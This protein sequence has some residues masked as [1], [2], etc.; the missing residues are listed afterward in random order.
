MSRDLTI[1]MMAAID[2]HTLRAI[3][4]LK[5]EINEWQGTKSSGSKRVTV[6]DERDGEDVKR[7]KSQARRE[8]FKLLDERSLGKSGWVLAKLPS[9]NFQNSKPFSL[10][11]RRSSAAVT[12]CKLGC[13]NFDRA[14]YNSIRSMG[15]HLN[16]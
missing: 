9:S 5:E 15:R 12:S 4:D 11:Q 13:P 3:Q 10:Q 6:K 2:R 8:A 14:E 1:C 16:G 7:R